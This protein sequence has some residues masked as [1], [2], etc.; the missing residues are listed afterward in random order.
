MMLCSFFSYQSSRPLGLV[1]QP[2]KKE[3]VKRLKDPHKVHL[4]N[5]AKGERDHHIVLFL[6]FLRIS[7]LIPNGYSAHYVL[8]MSSNH[9][10]YVYIYLK[11]LSSNNSVV[12]VPF[13]F[14]LN[15]KTKKKV[16]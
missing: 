1:S 12:L 11:I 15:L 14:Y 3:R 16:K 6:A 5:K 7:N 8:A 10:Q 9:S 4:I 2:K 13:F